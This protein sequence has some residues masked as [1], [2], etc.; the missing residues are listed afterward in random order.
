[1]FS[2][3]YELIFYI[4]E[5]AFFILAT[6]AQCI[7]RS[8]DKREQTA[9]MCNR[10]YASESCVLKIHLSDAHQETRSCCNSHPSGT[11]W[12]STLPGTGNYCGKK[13]VY[14]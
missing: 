13:Q 10:A 6:R 14:T 9:L 2:V 3:R 12:G 4:Q 8:A 1:V 11:T 7:R 5:T